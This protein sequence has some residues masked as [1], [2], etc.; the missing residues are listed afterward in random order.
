MLPRVGSG[1]LACTPVR[2]PPDNVRPKPTSYGEKAK[3]P[4]SAWAG[5][6]AAQQPSSALWIL[7]SIKDPTGCENRDLEQGAASMPRLIII[8]TAFVALVTV[9]NPSAKAESR[10]AVL[11]TKSGPCDAAYR[12]AVQVTNGIVQAEGVANNVLSGRVS[13]N[14]SVSV[15]GA[16]NLYGIAWGRLSGNSGA[17]SWRVQMQNE[18]CF[19]V[20]TARR[21]SR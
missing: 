18:K 6:F 13:P 15:R 17:G 16:A 14:G 8:T 10:F 11:A 12:G 7:T 5:G 4:V 2:L 3:P 20:W 1:R 9:A 19:G 21:L